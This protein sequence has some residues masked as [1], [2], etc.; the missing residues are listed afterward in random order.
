VVVSVER[1]GI[2]VVGHVEV[3]PAIVV[4][5]E[6]AH[7]E[8]VC[9]ARLRDPRR[10]GDVLERPVSLV[11]VEDVLAAGEPGRSAGHGHALVAAEAGVGCRRRLQVHVDVVRHE[12]VQPAV[13]VVV[14]E[15]A[16]GP[17]SRPRVAQSRA[18]GDVL[19]R[20]VSAVVVEVVLSPVAHEQVHV[21]VVVVVARARALS[22]AAL[23]EARLLR[24]V[25]E[26]PIA[27][28]AVEVVRGLLARREPFERRPVNEKDVEPPVSV[29]VEEGDAAPR[30]LEQVLVRLSASEHGH[31]VE[32]G[33]RS[34]TA[35]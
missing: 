6:R 3:R 23:G 13:A 16:A 12:E 5:V 22:P 35:K 19:E 9:P 11:A 8:A 27:L 4:E 20:P 33:F 2:R 26:R 21:P 15:G 14:E 34:G 29:V 24:D 18:D 10:V 31:R 7:A 25:L 28:V 1:G 30:R 17:P 32:T